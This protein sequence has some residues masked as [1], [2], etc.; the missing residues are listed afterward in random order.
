MNHLY[1]DKTKTSP[2]IKTKQ[3]YFLLLAYQ[4]TNYHGWQRQSSVPSVQQTIEEALSRIFKETIRIHGCGRTDAGVH[5]TRYYAQTFLPSWNFDLVERINLVLPTDISVLELIPV[6]ENANVQY[7]TQS[8]TYQYY[9]HLNKNPLLSHF[10]TWYWKTNPDLA[11]LKT[12]LK[13]LVGTRDF[14]AFCIRPDQYKDTHCIVSK[15]T[16]HTGDFPQ[17]YFIELTANRFLQQMIRLTVARL[18]DLSIGKITLEDFR[19][20]LE[21]RRPFVHHLPAPPQGLQLAEVAY[22]W[23]A[24]K[25]EEGKISNK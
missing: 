18:I 10:S 4:G 7:S 16:L 25:V 11:V 12:G 19:T 22:D 3:K 9:F 24:I 2:L 5:A 13:L 23:A 20:A 8:R 21:E 14:H 1:D 15:A 6:Q 17:S